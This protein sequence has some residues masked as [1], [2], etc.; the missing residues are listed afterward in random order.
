MDKIF[1][2]LVRTG[3]EYIKRSRERK[4]KETALE[5]ALLCNMVNK[6]QRRKQ[7]RR[8][9]KMKEKR[10]KQKQGTETK[11]LTDAT[12]TKAEEK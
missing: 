10:L 12:S 1:D 11:A 2:Q 3:E 5:N 9:K 8:L 4:V 7:I 6:K